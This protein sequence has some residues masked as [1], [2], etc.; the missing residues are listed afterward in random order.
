MLIGPWDHVNPSSLG[1]LLLP[2][3]Y[4]ARG[5]VDVVDRN[6]TGVPGVLDLFCQT[7]C[8]GLFPMRK[9]FVGSEYFSY[10]TKSIKWNLANSV[11]F[12]QREPILREFSNICVRW[13]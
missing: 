4:R 2:N 3:L 12:G 6:D 13:F 7:Y 9:T 11:E 1:F 10:L 5:V 8:N